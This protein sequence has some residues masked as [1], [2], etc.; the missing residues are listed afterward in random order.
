MDRIQ[1]YRL[2]MGSRFATRRAKNL[3]E[4]W[5]RKIAKTLDA[6]AEEE[7]AT[8]LLNCASQ[9]Y[10]GAVDRDALV[11]PVITPVFKEIKEG[12][13]RIVS[14]FS[15]K[16]RGAMARHIVQNRL[17]DPADLKGFTAGGYRYEADGSDSDTMLFTR[18]YQKA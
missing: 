3:Y 16:A 4:F 9:E 5:G 8:M 13:A 11:I 7:G 17:T 2:E 18:G 14:F 15:K 6:E 1:P 12:K 10:F